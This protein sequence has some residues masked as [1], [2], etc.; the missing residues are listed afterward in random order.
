MLNALEIDNKSTWSRIFELP[1]SCLKASNIKIDNESNDVFE[2]IKG[3][4]KN[5]NLN[6]YKG[7][8]KKNF[9]VKEDFFLVMYNRLML[10]SLLLDITVAWCSLA[11]V[12][13]LIDERETD[14]NLIDL[15]YCAAI[16]NN[17]AVVKHL[18][19]QKG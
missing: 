12:K 11:V 14:V 1:Q 7:G 5:K 3:I 4:L 2:Q 13:Y 15:T 10:L 6:T 8:K 17:L 9:D 16:S 19:D 18:I